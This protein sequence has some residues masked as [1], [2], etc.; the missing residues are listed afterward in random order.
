MGEVRPHLR[1]WRLQFDG[2]VIPDGMGIGARRRGLGPSFLL[3]LKSIRD[4]D[5]IRVGLTR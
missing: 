3:V 4:A 2:V 1:M 5:A